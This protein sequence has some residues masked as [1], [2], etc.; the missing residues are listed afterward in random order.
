M[1]MK[2][3]DKRTIM[4]KAEEKL[5]LRDWCFFL[6]RCKI[7]AQCNQYIILEEK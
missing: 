4:I 2:Y 3:L 1:R 7:V 6:I 5:S